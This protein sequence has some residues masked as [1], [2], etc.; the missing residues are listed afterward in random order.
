MSSKWIS[1]CKI[2]I[3][4]MLKTKLLFQ[5]ALTQFNIP[6]YSLFS[7]VSHKQFPQPKLST[8]TIRNGNFKGKTCKNCGLLNKFDNLCRKQKTRNASNLKK[9]LVKTS[10]EEP[11]PDYSV[12]YLHS[13]KVL[14]ESVC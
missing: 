13:S 7:L 11:H 14:Y 10:E 1:G 6:Q 9:K 12:N 5:Q 2:S 8:T 4:N 3:K